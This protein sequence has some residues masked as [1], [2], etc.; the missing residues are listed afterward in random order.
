[1]LDRYSS[2]RKEVVLPGSAAVVKEG[3][4]TVESGCSEQA[5]ESAAV[6]WRCQGTEEP[7]TREPCGG[8]GHRVV[9]PSG[10]TRFIG[11]RCH[12][13]QIQLAVSRAVVRPKSRRAAGPHQKRSKTPAS[14]MQEFQE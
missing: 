14:G 5:H 10:I 2:Q 12:H 4:G 7:I 6:P 9:E 13:H 3:A 11:V 1:V 8:P